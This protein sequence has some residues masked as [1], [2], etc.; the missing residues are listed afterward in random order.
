MDNGIGERQNQS[1]NIMRLA[2]MRQLYSD[3]KFLFN[4][5]F[6]ICVILV[7][8]GNV[9]SFVKTQNLGIHSVIVIIKLVSVVVPFITFDKWI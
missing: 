8:V 6:F 5:K 7:I 4:F 1:I 3:A 9:L 2:A